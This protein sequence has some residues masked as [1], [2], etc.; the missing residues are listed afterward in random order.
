MLYIFIH[1]KNRPKE[2]LPDDMLLI[3]NAYSNNDEIIKNPFTKVQIINPPNMNN[4]LLGDYLH[5][6]INWEDSQLIENIQN[7]WQNGNHYMFCTS[8]SMDMIPN[9]VRNY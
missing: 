9:Y 8:S 2:I 7:I 4:K 1:C 3:R 6:N 5:D